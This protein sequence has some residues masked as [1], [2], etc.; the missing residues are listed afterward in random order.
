MLTANLMQAGLPLA[1][2][3]QYLIPGHDSRKYVELAS[4]WEQDPLLREAVDGVNG[5]TW[6]SL[7]PEVRYKLAL[8]KNTAEMAYFL[9]SSSFI[10]AG[11]REDIDKMKLA[12]EV[13]KS[14]LGMKTQDDNPMDAFARFAIDL[15]RSMTQ[16]NMQK[17]AEK[18]AKRASPPG[19]S[20]MV[21]QKSQGNH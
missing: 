8:D 10:G 20:V 12:R 14:E 11:S 15:S 9:Y 5:G 2:A 16:E 4:A 6:A 7:A 17:S 13:M 1:L 3:I 19:I 21:T 18:S